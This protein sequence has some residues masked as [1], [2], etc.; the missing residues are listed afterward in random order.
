VGDIVIQFV[1]S[2]I[3]VSVGKHTEGR[4]P[5]ASDAVD[6]IHDVVTERIIFHFVDGVVDA[7]RAEE[8]DSSTKIDWSY[9]VWSGPLRNQR[10]GID[11][12]RPD[13]APS[14]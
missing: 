1:V 14:A 3:V 10:T 9:Y 11:W 6:F 12:Y 4:F 2:E 13:S 8:F 7:Y 5:G